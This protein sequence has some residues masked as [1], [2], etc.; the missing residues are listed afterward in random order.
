[1]DVL[2]IFL[3]G[4]AL[5]FGWS[6]YRQG[7]VVGILSLVGFVGGG[8]L[9]AHVAA[10][11]S[12]G[13]GL[14]SQG[15]APV[16]GLLCL[17]GFAIAGQV[18]AAAVGGLVRKRLTG[19][20]LRRLDSAGGAVVSAVSILLVCWGLAQ[21]VVRTDYRTLTRQIQR[22]FVLGR[23]NAALPSDAGNLLA[24]LLRLVDSSGFPQVFGG[25]GSEQIVPVDPPD[26]SVLQQPGVKQAHTR[27]VKVVGDAPS[28][29]RRIEGSGFVFAPDHVM[30]NAHVVAGVHSPSVLTDG[31]KQLPAQVVLYDSHRDVAVLYVPDLGLAPLPFAGP[32]D[33]GAEGVVVGYPE[34]GPFTAS[35]A[36]VRARQKIRGPDIYQSSTVT[37]EVY[38]LYADVR[39]GN[40]GGPLLSPDA[41]V[42]GVVFAAST[43]LANTGYAL[44]AAEVASDA[45][46]GAT[47]TA[48]VSTHG[49]D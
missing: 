14:T 38:V 20:S 1:M 44:T 28:C 7:F 35:P 36:R 16:F 3:L 8:L 23:V 43:S 13:L 47:A 19:H 34:D 22:S 46:A 40:S 41:K 39:P 4:L 30:T 11:L 5:G 15:R 37:R 45:T 21:V 26:P 12:T 18:I 9:G 27:I 10:P 48:P 32:V 33:R 42:D 31:G 29:S 2:D 6:G 17:V 49:C 25:F 24:A